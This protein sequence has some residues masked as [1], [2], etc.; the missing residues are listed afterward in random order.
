M[1]GLKVSSIAYSSGT[2]SPPGN[3]RH[4]LKNLGRNCDRKESERAAHHLGIAAE[5]MPSP[6][7]TLFIE[8]C[9]T[10]RTRS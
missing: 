2:S 1:D 7:P 5:R 4:C 6:K 9:S 10:E 3:G 8:V